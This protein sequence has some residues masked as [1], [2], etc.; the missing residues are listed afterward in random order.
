MWLNV[1]DRALYLKAAED[2]RSNPGQLGAYESEGHCV[3]LAGP[4]SG[5]TKILT[6]KLAKLLAEDVHNPRGVACIT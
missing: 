1:S 6:V 5:K 2:F 3:V 4:G